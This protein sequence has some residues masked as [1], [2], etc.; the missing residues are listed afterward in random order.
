MTGVSWRPGC[1]VPLDDLRAVVVRFWG[2][3]GRAH[4]GGRLIVHADVAAGVRDAFRRLYEARFPIRRIEP[5]DAYGASDDRSM[6]ANNTSAFNCRFA[7]GSDRRWSEHAFGRAIDLN[8]VQNPWVPP[9]GPILPPAGAEYADRS[10]VRPGMVVEGDAVTAAF[11]AIGW[12]WGGRW[13]S[14][15]DYQHFSASGR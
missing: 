15:K 12:G 14:V 2:F 3:D 5:V 8:P 6:A 9:G 13:S 7:T 1:P 11:D 4:D 10:D